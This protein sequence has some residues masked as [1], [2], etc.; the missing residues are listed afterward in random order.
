MHEKARSR[1]GLDVLNLLI[2]DL[3]TGVGAFLAIY[4]TSVRAWDARTVGALVAMQSVVG[5]LA[6]APSGA[7]VDWTSKKKW[8]L[9][10][11]PTMIS[12]GCIGIV[13]FQTFLLELVAQSIIGIAAAI[14]VPA[15]SA[16]SL[17]IVGHHELPARIARN[18]SMYHLGNIGF[19]LLAGVL[20]QK[21]GHHL[22]F[23]EAAA[24]SFAA[25]TAAAVLIRSRDIDDALAREAP[26]GSTHGI[27]LKRTFLRR[28]VLGF[29]GAVAL[30][31][32]ANGPMLPL[33]GEIFAHAGG[34]SAPYMAACIVV[35]QLVMIPV[36]I[37]TG[38]L[39]ERWGRKPLFLFA[40]AAL[41]T[42]ALAY[43]IWQQPMALVWLQTVDALGAGVFGVMWAV[44]AADLARGTG[45]F[46][47][48]QGAVQAAVGVGVFLGNVVAG[49]AVHNA[50]YRA[51]FLMLAGIAFAGLGTYAAFVPET[52][53]RPP[54]MPP[55]SDDFRTLPRSS[56]A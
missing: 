21:L 13:V 41:V 12:L 5:V 28:P 39:S 27:S 16:V 36:A 8:L 35:A 40:F 38:R 20:G 34:Q 37:A 52:R 11:S 17:G 7:L 10:I 53:A 45:H 3:Q 26:S 29:L 46:G 15:V 47:L 2:A 50:G 55:E 31:H 51:V 18:E 1:R 48:M 23:F 4:L 9:V 43:T 22:I 56:P 44:V 14:F 19:A 32:F 49:F 25:G 6:Q 30:F 42:R 54:A 24:T 33:I